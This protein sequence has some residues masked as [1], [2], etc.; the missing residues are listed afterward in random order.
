M[1]DSVMVMSIAKSSNSLGLQAISSL[2]IVSCAFEVI[3]FRGI[4]LPLQY[5]SGITVAALL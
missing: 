4:E 1:S 3:R 2:R 5:F